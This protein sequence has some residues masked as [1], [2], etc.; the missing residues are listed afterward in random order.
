MLLSVGVFI[1]TLL[2]STRNIQIHS[3]LFVSMID[4]V[5]FVCTIVM[6]DYILVFWV[7]T[8]TTLRFAAVKT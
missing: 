3:L 2:R 1:Y 6:Y 5:F 7:V 4:F 8:L